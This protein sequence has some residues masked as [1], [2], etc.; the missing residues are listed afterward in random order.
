MIDYL[1]E[2]FTTNGQTYDVVLDAVGKHSFVRARRALARD[3]AYAATDRL[4]NLPLALLT[5]RS[6]KKVVFTIE[7]RPDRE[8]IAVVKELVETGK[9]RPVIDRVYPLEDVVAATRYV[10]TWRKVGNVVLA[11]NGVGS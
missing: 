6:R 9:Y 8:N 11:L 5:S 10:D 7:R 4:Y 1:R 3:G 2:D